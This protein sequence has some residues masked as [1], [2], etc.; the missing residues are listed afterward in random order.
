MV[1]TTDDKVKFAYYSARLK[2]RDLAALLEK[3]GNDPSNTD[4]GYTWILL[5]QLAK[6]LSRQAE[7]IAF[8]CYR[9]FKQK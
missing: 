9:N 3:A 1:N 5:S 7:Q 8:F 6:D 4:P 2:I